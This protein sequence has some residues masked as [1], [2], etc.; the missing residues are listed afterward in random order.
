MDL[1]TLLDL[2]RRDRLP[3]LRFFWGHHGEGPGPWMLSQWYPSPFT[4]DG[5]RYATA[6]HWMM[7][8]KAR[9]FGDDDA[10]QR[11]LGTD[12]PVQ[13]KA[14]GRAVRGFDAARWSEAADEVVLAGSIAKFT[15]TD[16]LRWYLVG[17]A[18]AVLV[19]ASPEDTVWGIGLT[20]RH[21][22]AWRPS[23]WRGTNRLGFALTA[24]RER[25][26]RAST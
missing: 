13:A 16:E 7:A 20:A 2:E 23:R 10:L 6:E 15:S 24:A 26:A 17:T 4:V 25:I 3:P 19:E 12:D 11:V 9:L 21:R 22:D 1:T 8:A 18:P 5:V 14:A